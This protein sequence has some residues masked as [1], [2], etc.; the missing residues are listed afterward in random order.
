MTR[1]YHLQ[2]TT[3][4]GR[5]LTGWYTLEQWHALLRTILGLDVEVLGWRDD[6][7]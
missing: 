2:L 6:E 3:G 1:R 4:T 5:Q 7:E